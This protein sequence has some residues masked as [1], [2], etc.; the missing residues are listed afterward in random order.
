MNGGWQATLSGHVWL[1]FA[2][3]DADGDMR[4]RARAWRLRRI[5]LLLVM[6]WLTVHFLSGGW[7]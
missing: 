5:A 7:A 6:A 3:K 2:I 1:A 4:G